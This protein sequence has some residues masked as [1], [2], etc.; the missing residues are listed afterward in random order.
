M[1]I[2]MTLFD[3]ESF[4]LSPVRLNLVNYYLYHQ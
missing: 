3:Y 1:K 4:D 2:L